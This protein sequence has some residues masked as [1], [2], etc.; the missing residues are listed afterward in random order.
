[1]WLFCFCT[2]T[3]FISRWPLLIA[4][5]SQGF[6]QSALMFII[7]GDYDKSYMGITFFISL[8]CV[9]TTGVDKHQ[10]V[11]QVSICFSL[12]GALQLLPNV[13]EH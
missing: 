13:F 6:C 2:F 10:D 12:R 1:M 8:G 3:V 5:D 9:H 11:R 4:E 7:F